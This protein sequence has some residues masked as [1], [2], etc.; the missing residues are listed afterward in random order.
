MET[1]K[2]KHHALI[3]DRAAEALADLYH[4]ATVTYPRDLRGR[5]GGRN[6]NRG[7]KKSKR[8]CIV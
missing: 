6:R 4:N 3:R 1:R 5:S 2:Q 7:S 8:R